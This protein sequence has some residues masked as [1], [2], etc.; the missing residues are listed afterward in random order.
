MKSIYVYTLSYIY[1]CICIYNS[2]YRIYIRAQE[3]FL[4]TI[5]RSYLEVRTCEPCC[6]FEH[7]LWPFNT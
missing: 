7:V 6:I 5:I 3:K 2:S 4:Q 1:I